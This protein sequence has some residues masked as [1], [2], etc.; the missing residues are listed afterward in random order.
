M[1]IKFIDLVE[2]IRSNISNDMEYIFNNSLTSEHMN[3]AVL[4]YFYMLSKSNYGFY[5]NVVGLIASDHYKILKNSNYNDE[6]NDEAFYFIN[7]YESISSQDELISIIEEE[8]FVLLE[9]LHWTSEF[10]NCDYFE[11]RKYYLNCKDK[12]DV[13]IKLSSFSTLDFLYHCQKYDMNTIKSIYKEQ[14]NMYNDKDEAINTLIFNLEELFRSDINNYKEL[15]A[16]LLDNYYLIGKRQLSSDKKI[17]KRRYL[18]KNI[19]L[20]ENEDIVDIL[21]KLRDKDC[22]FFIEIL[23]RILNNDDEQLNINDNDSLQQKTLRKIKDI[24]QISIVE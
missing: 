6:L 10:N 16:D 3:R 18:S 19:K 14:L 21:N 24:K 4:Y 9:L 12:L 8:P 17:T 1:I 13:L 2:E 5:K 11:K 23:R 7:L 20:I 15:V 22:K